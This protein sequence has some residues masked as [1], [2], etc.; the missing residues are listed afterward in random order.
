M[1]V[2]IFGFQA[3]SVTPSRS[4]SHFGKSRP[5]DMAFANYRQKPIAGF[6][7]SF[8]VKIQALIL[9]GDAGAADQHEPFLVFS[10]FLTE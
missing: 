6:C 9:D 10:E 5:F 2:R 1:M 8:G 7:K 4:A 3:V